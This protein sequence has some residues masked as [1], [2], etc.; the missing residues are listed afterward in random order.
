[1][2][3]RDD[4]THWREHAPW[5][6]DFQVEQDLVISR[7]LV[8]IF[9]DPVLA[10]ALAFRGG[11]ALYKLYLMPPARYSEDIDLIQIAPGPAGPQTIPGIDR[12]SASAILA[13]VGPDLDAFASAERLA[14]W[15]GVCPGN[16][17]SAGKRRGGRARMGKRSAMSLFV[18]RFSRSEP[19]ASRT[20][21]TAAFVWRSSKP[22]SRRRFA[23]V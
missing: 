3:P 12:P 2:I 20:I 5:S 18:A 15:A 16:D 4:I 17:R 6:E 10:G 11:T 23:A 21:D 9:S 14:A 8:A 7:A 13:E 1:M 19:T 22:A